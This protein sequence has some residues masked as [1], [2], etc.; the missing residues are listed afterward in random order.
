MRYSVVLR[1]D[2][3]GNWLAS[4][5][6]LP[7]CHTWGG[8]KQEA[9]ANVREAIEGC[10]GR[11]RATVD[12]MPKEESTVAQAA[13]PAPG[14]RDKA[15]ARRDRQPHALRPAAPALPARGGRQRDSRPHRRRTAPP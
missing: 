3:E 10:I 4:V 7:G 1:Q 12:S 2:D 6:T 5:P 11:I 9:M 8:T 14:T 13:A 15:A